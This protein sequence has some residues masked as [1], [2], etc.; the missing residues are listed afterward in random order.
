MLQRLNSFN[1]P[2]IEYFSFADKFFI[3]RQLV[4]SGCHPPPHPNPPLANALL[5][6][7]SSTDN[8][9]G[10]YVHSNYVGSKLT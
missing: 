3:F 4:F 7:H 2:F 1:R 6:S 8:N 5:V 10:M 9:L